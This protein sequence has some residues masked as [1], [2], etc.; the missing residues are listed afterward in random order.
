MWARLLQQSIW[1]HVLAAYV[2]GAQALPHQPDIVGGS[3]VDILQLLKDSGADLTKTN[4][5]G[6]TP[7][8]IMLAKHDVIFDGPRG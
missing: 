1:V 6:L 8:D 5:K 7:A 4:P 3:G 2:W